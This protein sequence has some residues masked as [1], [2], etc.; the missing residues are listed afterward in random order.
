MY[1]ANHGD[2]KRSDRRESLAKR[3]RKEEEKGEAEG[4]HSREEM[5]IR[6]N[7]RLDMGEKVRIGDSDRSGTGMVDQNTIFT[8]RK[9]IE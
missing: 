6:C 1:G 3:K 9:K 8:E 7:V 2:R 4:D 5:Q